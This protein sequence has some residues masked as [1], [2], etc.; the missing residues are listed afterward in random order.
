MYGGL[1]PLL[2][3]PHEDVALQ[4]CRHVPPRPP[5]VTVDGC[6]HIA[7]VSQSHINAW[8]IWHNLETF[9]VLHTQIHIPDCYPLSG[10]PRKGVQIGIEEQNSPNPL[11][12]RYAFTCCGRIT[13]KIPSIL[14]S[15]LLVSFYEIQY[16]GTTLIPHWGH[17]FIT[18]FSMLSPVLSSLIP[19]NHM[20]QTVPLGHI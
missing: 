20:L 17:S 3:T 9:T 14:I 6:P 2:H 12:C 15:S 19:S 7:R 1:G 16:S 10:L 11:L 8:W 13:D 4:P 5:R 18:T